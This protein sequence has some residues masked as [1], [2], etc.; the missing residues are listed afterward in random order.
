MIEGIDVRESIPNDTPSLEKIYT[1]VFPE[2]DLLP[3]VRELLADNSTCLSLVA[4]VD[5]TLV[6]HACFTLCGVAGNTERVALLGPVAV[7]SAWQR[8][9]IGGRIIRDGIARM[10]DLQAS[11]ICVLGDPGY[12]SR[13]GFRAEAGIMPPYNL[14][15]EYRDAWQSVLLRGSEDPVEGRLIVPPPWQHPALWSE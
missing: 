14:P 5:G 6:A 7:A 13:L 1:E 12:Y 4:I 11:G 15:D 10:R 2:E 9:G 3:L 8:H